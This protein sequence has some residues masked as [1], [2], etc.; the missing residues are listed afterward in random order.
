MRTF[1]KTLPSI[2]FLALIPVLSCS[3]EEGKAN[4]VAGKDRDYEIISTPIKTSDPDRIEVVEA[5]WYGCSHCYH[6]EPFLEPWVAKLPADVYFTGLPVAWD[7]PTRVLHSKLYYTARQLNK[8]DAMHA[9]TFKAMNLAPHTLNT[10][11]GIA[12]FFA[13]HGVTNAD[14]TKT[15]RSFSV[16]SQVKQ[17]DAKVRSYDIT[18]TPTLIINGKY[19]IQGAAPKKML[20]IADFLI[21]KE[22]QALAEAKK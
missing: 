18:G 10:E 1:L 11:D 5:F 2:F 3:A 20:E 8:L 13:E 17:A 14:F 12:K 7:N 4:F 9:A 6:F 22:R 16:D 19:R 15:F 21:N